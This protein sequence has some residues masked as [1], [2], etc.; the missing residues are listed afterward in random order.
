MASSNADAFF[1]FQLTHSRGV[2]L[3]ADGEKA[4][5]SMISTHALTWSATQHH[6]GKNTNISISTHALTWS[7]TICFCICH[8]PHLHFNSRTHVE[9]D[10]CDFVE[11]VIKSDFNSRTHVECDCTGIVRLRQHKISTHALTWSATFVY[12]K[13]GIVFAISTHALTWSATR[14][15]MPAS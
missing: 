15:P 4:E 12:E 13:N 6:C 10:L 1:K 3:D 8:S 9:C 2:R 14:Q 7:A 5:Q 11:S